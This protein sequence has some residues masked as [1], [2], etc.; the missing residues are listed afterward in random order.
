MVGFFTSP[1]N[2]ESTDEKPQR[3]EI[4]SSTADKSKAVRLLRSMR[5]GTGGSS[6]RG[7]IKLR[8]WLGSHNKEA[9]VRINV[10]HPWNGQVV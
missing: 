7:G 4:P 6:F 5:L 1:S 9:G 8:P 10:A 3:M 2:S